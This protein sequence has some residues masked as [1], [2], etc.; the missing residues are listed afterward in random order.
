MLR[1]QT[2][3]STTASHS[4][5][6]ACT[7]LVIADPMC[8]SGTLLIEAAL[9]ATNT[10]VGLQ[11]RG[12]PFQSWFDFDESS[13]HEAVE[14]AQAA[15]SSWSGVILGNDIHQVGGGVCRAAIVLQAIM[16]P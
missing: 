3:R 2:T 13:W 14:S 6:R 10:A 4:C 11:R 16:E 9:M 1:T 7:D 15:H 8:G 12:W 5:L